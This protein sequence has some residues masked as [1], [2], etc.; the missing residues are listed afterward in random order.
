VLTNPT[1]LPNGTFVFAFTNA[2]GAT[3]SALA[4]TN[5]ALPR[6]NWT[7]LGA[8]TEISP[9]I[10]QFSDSQ[11]ATNPQRFYSVKAN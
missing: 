1:K 7:T 11:A 3:F 2:A 4:T 6:T 9:G 10:F 5:L 8:V